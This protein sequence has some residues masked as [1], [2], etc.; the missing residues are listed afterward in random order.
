MIRFQSNEMER[1]RK[2]NKTNERGILVSL[3]GSVN[4]RDDPGS[5]EI[6]RSSGDG[7]EVS[8]GRESDGRG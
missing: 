5:E 4:R 1:I 6:R 7:R 8:I 3:N 2:P